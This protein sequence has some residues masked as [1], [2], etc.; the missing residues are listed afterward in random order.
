M[1][2][3][4]SIKAARNLQRAGVDELVFVGD[5]AAS[6]DV[7]SQLN[8]RQFRLNDSNFVAGA[9]A[10]SS[11][12]AA[13][14]GFSRWRNFFAGETFASSA[15]GARA[16][17]LILAGL[18]V[19]CFKDGAHA[20]EEQ[21]RAT[22]ELFGTVV[23]CELL[24]PVD[25]NALN[26]DAVLQYEQ[27]NGLVA[28]VEMLDNQSLV[29][30]LGDSREFC[31]DLAVHVD[32]SGWF[33][34]SAIA[35][36]KM[37]PAGGGGG[38]SSSSSS[39]S[40]GSSSGGGGGGGGGGGSAAA[41]PTSPST[42]M[43][44]NHHSASA[45][46]AAATTSPPGSSNSAETDVGALQRKL[47]AEIEAR[48]RSE[49]EAGKVQSRLVE[50]LQSR[51]AAESKAAAAE[52]KAAEEVANRLRIETAARE[53]NARAARQ[54]D[55]ELEK[56]KKENSHLR[57][58]A[59]GEG[60]GNGTA[61]GKGGGNGAA[62]GGVV[63]FKRDQ[64]WPSAEEAVE[65]S[66]CV[67]C[68]RYAE[69]DS[70]ETGDGICSMECKKDQLEGHA[71]LVGGRPRDAV[72]PTTAKCELSLFHRGIIEG[73]AVSPGCKTA[74]TVGGGVVKAWNIAAFGEAHP[75]P[76][77]SVAV[78]SCKALKFCVALDEQR[79]VT[80]GDSSSLHVCDA[81][82][83]AVDSFGPDA[84]CRSNF[85]A[86][87][88]GAV[89]PSRAKRYARQATAAQY[90]AAAHKLGSPLHFVAS[91]DGEIHAWDLAT[92]EQIS[93]FAGHA[94]AVNAIAIA[95]DGCTMV[96]GSTDGCVL[97]WNLL[98]VTSQSISFP[99]PVTAIAVSPAHKL[100]MIG[101]KNGTIWSL[102]L[103]TFTSTL[104]CSAHDEVGSLTFAPSGDWF[105]ST[106]SDKK[107]EYSLVNVWEIS[108]TKPVMQIKETEVAAQGITSSAISSDGRLLV[109][110]SRSGM[111]K[112]YRLK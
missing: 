106:G 108:S 7:A 74:F 52:S 44:L 59:G 84:N 55:A 26:F 24:P 61:A 54:Y 14:V 32:L 33:S 98:D 80:G 36:R 97:V 31:V 4:S 69:Y 5:F 66:A 53:A 70:S 81:G 42:Y 29:I 47:N 90:Y 19:R 9:V 22:F 58:A 35:T 57:M 83:A 28:A 13:G 56:L 112:V 92:K 50:E 72:I 40:G 65:G 79:V 17:T 21:V 16:D 2:S 82:K 68:G 111:A 8:G 107:M 93:V 109:T 88:P 91:S 1:E 99:A 86:W 64:R 20:S 67:M 87:Q 96:S 103:Q 94:R 76:Y 41:E 100:A 12:G 10:A 38:G 23:Q 49:V 30:P 6:K 78:G 62:A 89:T 45:S 104:F 34:E 27:E 39:S 71:P 48:R 37:N 85:P 110:G 3:T 25:G 15:A 105:V 60:G 101:L 102:E 43:Q 46:T 51:S 75:Q 77:S 18:P 73:L 11:A 63:Q 95:A